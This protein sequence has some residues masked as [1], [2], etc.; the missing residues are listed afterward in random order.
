MGWLNV[1]H[2]AW[3]ELAQTKAQARQYRTKLISVDVP[4]DIF[5]GRRAGDDAPCLMVQTTVAP[6]T[7][8]E[9]EGMRLSA[10]QDRS[11]PFLVLSLEDNARAD[12]FGAVCAD[13][14]GATIQGG[15]VRGADCFLARL[16][17]WRKF[18]RERRG[19]WSRSETIG[20]IGE[21]LVLEQILGVDSQGLAGWQAPYDG[22]QD[23]LSNG[24]ALEVKTGLGPSSTITISALDQLDP[25]GLTKLV[26]LH[27]RLVEAPDG[28]S[29]QDIIDAISGL[30]PD[31]AARR[32]FENALLRRGLMPDNQ[33]ARTGPRVQRRSLDAY[34]VSETF[35]RLVRAALPIAITEAT[36]TLDVRA[37]S[38]FA[39]DA[40]D[41]LKEFLDGNDDGR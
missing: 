20:L 11:R 34:S 23:F 12:L 13:V 2:E 28:R 25:A 22:L 7:V 41:A 4:L 33:A 37:L 15:A 3:N 39:A 17:A 32:D 5:A 9:L 36:Y 30:L 38:A 6:P 29:M 19:G 18:L 16:D 40:A 1:L 31:A 10:F 14:I 27:V 24:H 8:F 21:L 35:P 26:L